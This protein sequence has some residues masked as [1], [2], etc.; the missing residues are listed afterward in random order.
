[1]SLGWSRL[2]GSPFVRAITSPEDHE[3]YAE[4][5]KSVYSGNQYWVQPDT[6]HVVSIL[7]GR[8]PQAEHSMVQP[9]WVERDGKILATVTAVVDRAYNKHWNERMGHLLFFEALSDDMKAVRD[10]FMTACEWLS[11]K[12]CTA[13]RLEFL[14]GWQLPLTIDAYEAIPTFLHTY[15]PPY[16]H[17]YVKDSGF[18]TEHGVVEYQVRFTSETRESYQSHVSRAEEQGVKLRPWDFERLEEET[19]LFTRLVNETFDAHWGSPQFT[20]REMLELTAGMRGV[21][22][23][24]FL[25]FA[26]VDD[27]PAGFVFALPDLNQTHGRHNS[28]SGDSKIDRGVLLIIGVRQ[29]FRGLGINLAL[30]S[31]SFLAMMDKGYR[32]ASYTVVLDDNWPSRRTA[33]KLHAHVARNFVVYRRNLVPVAI[34]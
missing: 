32:S 16:Y 3:R 2:K 13:A 31:R 11:K 8:T 26:E 24:E 9:F 22:V 19:A 21:L 27:E 15:N 7:G 12:G 1:M 18:V 25:A 23:P 17:S 33:E 28:G 29:A 20:V 14:F 6:E 34:R 10:L 5:A 4:F 30:G